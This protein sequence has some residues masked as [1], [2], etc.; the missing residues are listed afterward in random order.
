MAT[1]FKIEEIQK[2]FI[3]EQFTQKKLTRLLNAALDII[4][5]NGALSRKTD[6]GKSEVINLHYPVEYIDSEYAF[7]LEFFIN[8]V[9]MKSGR[10][11]T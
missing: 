11:T 5:F 4:T 2:D 8:N 3:K 6:T 9:K 10:I 1:K 7:N